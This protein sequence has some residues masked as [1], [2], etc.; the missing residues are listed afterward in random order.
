[1]SD[2]AY[3]AALKR[4]IAPLVRG[5]RRSEH[6]H[7]GRNFEFFEKGDKVLVC[8]GIGPEAARRAT[9]AV[10]ALHMPTEVVSVGFAGALEAGARVGDVFEPAV[11]VDARDGSRANGGGQGV[12]VSFGAV[13]DV[14]Q[15]KK[16]A[17]AYSAQL[18][19]M[20]AA[21]VALGAQA[22]GLRFRAVKAV[23]DE[24][25]FP[26][27]PM[28]RFVDSDGNFRNSSFLAF[29]AVRP[30]MW[31]V[32]FRLARN[33]GVASRALCARLKVEVEQHRPAFDAATKG[34]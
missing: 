19:D 30:Q 25:G 23:S 1:M 13:A 33:S 29:V 20:E 9:E 16:L 22:H 8:A 2:V 32:V 11:I 18:V 26:M 34:Q 12:L 28:D 24:F 7:S 15:K 10:V 31:L 21:S 14:A 4:E 3:V 17:S 6:T 5:W 27:P